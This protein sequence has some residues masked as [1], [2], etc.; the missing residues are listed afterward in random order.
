MS[1]EFQIFLQ[2]HGIISQRSC[3]FTPQQ[4]GMAERKNCHLL[5]VVRTLL[6][7][8]CVPSH[9][10]CEALCI[11][12]YLINRL[13]SPNLNNDSPYF[14]LFGH[15]PNYSN[16]HI[17]GC[18]CFVHLPAHERNKLTAQSIKCAFL[19]YV[20]TQKGF[21]CY[22]PHARRTRVSRNVIFFEN[23]PF[24]RTQH[25][26]TLPSLS[27]LPYFPES[28]TPIQRFK[29]G[30]VYHRRTPA[31]DPF[32]G[33]TKVPSHL[34]VASD[35]VLPTSYDPPLLHKSSRPH[36]PP[37]RYGF[38]TPVAMST[39]LCFVSIPTCYKQARE[40]ECW[41]Q[42]MEAELQALEANHTWDIISCPPYVKPI[43][44]K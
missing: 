28:P 16:L 33:L 9:F 27:V 21:L 15:A 22:D 17:F 44:S 12:V 13:P 14:R 35:S 20:G 8:S 5:D 4:N 36:R 43:G 26:S 37:E 32:T 7:E 30:Y 19:G 11:V 29:P 41:Q 38:S 40:H 31:S 1:N 2:S 24:F 25:T 3:P 34:L 23:Q 42:A 6:I 39:T 18:V 10:W